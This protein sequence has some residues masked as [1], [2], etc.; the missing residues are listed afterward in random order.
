M[1][2]PFDHPAFGMISLSQAINIIPNRYNRLGDLGLFPDKPQ[3]FRQIA[4][5]E[6]HGVLNLLPLLPPGSGQSHLPP[7]S[8]AEQ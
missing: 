7:R 6:E 4:V 5:E 3:R 8:E 1:L 2:N